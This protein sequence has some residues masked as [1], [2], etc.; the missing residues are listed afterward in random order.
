MLY[1]RRRFQQAGFE[2]PWRSFAL[3]LGSV[4]MV[5]ASFS[6]VEGHWTATAIPV[7]V[8]TSGIAILTLLQWL[9]LSGVT[10][11]RLLSL[12]AREPGTATTPALSETV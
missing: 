11:H 10:R 5:G 4:F 2:L 1:T 8:G 9:N 6:A 12:L 3:A 7:F